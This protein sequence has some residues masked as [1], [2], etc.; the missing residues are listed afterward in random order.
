MSYT[1]TGRIQTRVVSTLPAL[2]V[3]LALQR[4]WAIELVALMLGIGLALDA[5]VYH[6]VFSYQPAWLALPLGA[7]ELGLVYSAM[8]WLELMAPLRWALGLYA[9]AWVAA[10]VFGHAVFP[11]LHLEYAEDGGELGRRGALTAVAVAAT[12]VG[13]LGAAYAVKPPT[14]HLHGTIQG[15][16]VIRHAQTLVGGTV[17]GGILIRASHVTLRN[18]T[19]I[20]G[21]NGID[22]LDS[23]QVMLDNVR[24]VGVSLD[25]IHVRRSS[26]MIENCKITAPNGPW[27]QGIDISFSMDKDMSMV[28][29]CT[30]VGVREGIVTHMTMVDVTNNHIGATSLRGITMGEMSMGSIH[31]NDILGAHGVGIICLDHS[32]CDIQHNTIV[33]T[34]TDPSGDPSR[35]GVAIEAHFFANAKVKHNTV[36]ASPGGVAA[37]DQSTLTR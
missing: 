25:G 1:L 4:W 23:H 35:A 11:R 32:E 29:G 9:I 16:L 24:V 15:P 14:V 19:V 36:I 7:I 13:G 20:G 2:L 6:R 26:V 18:V 37:F 5:L 17:S 3:A 10:Q 21:E 27:V 22:I 31:S 33:G 8:R 28:D 12:V 34:R 30:I